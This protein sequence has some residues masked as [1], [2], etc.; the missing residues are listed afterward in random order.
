MRRATSSSRFVIGGACAALVVAGPGEIQ[1]GAAV[2][3]EEAV[4]DVRR[5][6][7]DEHV[8]CQ[9]KCRKSRREAGDEQKSAEGLGGAHERCHE[10]RHGDAE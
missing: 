1:L 10:D 8:G 2:L 7:G 6:E 5:Q 4:T 9:T 3:H